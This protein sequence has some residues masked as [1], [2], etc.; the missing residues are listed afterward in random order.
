MYYKINVNSVILGYCSISV[1]IVV[2]ILQVQNQ[3]YYIWDFLAFYLYF[4]IIDNPHNQI[5]HVSMGISFNLFSYYD[6]SGY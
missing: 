4:Q 5:T 1:K 6:V 2:L 3:M